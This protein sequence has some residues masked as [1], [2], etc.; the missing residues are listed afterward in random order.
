MSEYHAKQCCAVAPFPIEVEATLTQSA[1][2]Q[3]SLQI[4]STEFRKTNWMNITPEAFKA[5][6]MILSDMPE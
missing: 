3:L 2:G 4:R 5:I 1:N 6:E